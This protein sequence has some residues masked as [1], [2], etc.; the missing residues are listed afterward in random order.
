MVGSGSATQGAKPL[1]LNGKRILLVIAGGIAAYKSLDLIRRLRERGAAVRAILTRAGAAFVTPLAVGALAGEK[2]YTDLFSLTDE[3]A[4]GH[5]R[6]SRE[7]DLIVIAPATADLLAKMAA[8]LAD[9]LASTVLLA[10]NTPILAAPGMNVEMWEHAATRRNVERLAADG[11]AFVGPA[12]GDLA[13]GEVGQGRMAEVADIVAAAERLL[14]DA[15][16]GGL[17][18]DGRHALVTAGPTREPL[19][20]VRFLSNYS[21]GKQGFAIAGALAAR[22]ARTTLIAGPTA[23]PNPP[24]VTIVAVETAADMLAACEAALPADVAVFAAAVADW[25]VARRNEVKIKKAG[26]T[27]TLALIEN[28]DILAT[29][30]RRSDCRPTLVVGFAAETGAAPEQGRDKLVRKGCDWIVAND[31]S[32]GAVFGA[33][34]NRVHIVTPAGT[35]SWPELTKREVA[36]RLAVRIATHFAGPHAAE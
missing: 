23:L 11:I 4:M 28:P 16:G 3:S 25:R 22:G 30:A 33:E 5:I 13:C 6:L 10:A 36:E 8:G 31:V 1:S 35:E 15:A 20:P 26:E 24:G 14:A 34:R 21:S 29:I 12:A 32:G 27:P 19:D 17:R 7:S 9:D 18:L 2:A